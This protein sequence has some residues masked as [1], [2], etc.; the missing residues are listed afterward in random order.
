MGEWAGEWDGR[1]AV[2]VFV[3]RRCLSSAGGRIGRHRWARRSVGG[4]VSRHRWAHWPAALGALAVCRVRRGGAS[5]APV[6]FRTN[7]PAGSG[8]QGALAGTAG[9]VGCLPRWARRCSGGFEVFQVR[10]CVLWRARCGALAL[11]HYELP[12]AKVRLSVEKYRC[13]IGKGGDAVIVG[14]PFGPQNGKR[15][16]SALRNRFRI[17]QTLSEA[18]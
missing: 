8:L 5:G 11:D 14:R 2:C 6:R 16:G 18:L 12:V 10:R 15:C 13:L 1:E 3:L 7:L 4:R 17:P 9:S